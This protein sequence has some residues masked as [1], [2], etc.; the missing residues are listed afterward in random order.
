MKRGKK[1]QY[2]V[3]SSFRSVRFVVLQ[4][5][6][7]DDDEDERTEYADLCPGEAQSQSN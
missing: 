6:F 1:K 2:G 4:R 7:N 3:K 5:R